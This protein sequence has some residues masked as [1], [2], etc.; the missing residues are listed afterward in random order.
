MEIKMRGLL[1]EVSRL[2]S[3]LCFPFSIWV[4]ILPLSGLVTSLYPSPRN[5]HVY[6]LSHFLQRFSNRDQKSDATK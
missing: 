6:F 4:I 5:I 2:S 1:Q 3:S